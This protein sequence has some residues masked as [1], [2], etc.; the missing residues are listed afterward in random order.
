MHARSNWSFKAYLRGHLENNL[1]YT[2]SHHVVFRRPRFPRDHDTIAKVDTIQRV[3][4]INILGVT[5]SDTLTL[6]THVSNLSAKCDQL[7]FAL[8]TLR[9]HG[10]AGTALW[11][12]TRTHIINSLTYASFAWWGFCGTGE[13]RAAAEGCCR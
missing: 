5:I 3:F 9:Y 8:K 6:S 4:E 12:V 1:I 7:S 13:K 2:K 11:E 10:L